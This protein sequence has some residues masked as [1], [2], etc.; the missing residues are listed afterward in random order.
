MTTTKILDTILLERHRKHGLHLDEMSDD[1][2]VLENQY[3]KPVA[4][5]AQKATVE[6]IH[7]EAD[8]WLRENDLV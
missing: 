2:V 1:F 3:N 4:Y 7:K 5:F 8:K 6:E